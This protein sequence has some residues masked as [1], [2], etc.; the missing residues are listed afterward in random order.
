MYELENNSVVELTIE[1]DQFGNL[2]VKDK[3]E[4]TLY[5]PTVGVTYGICTSKKD[6]SVDNLMCVGFRYDHAPDNIY[7]LPVIIHKHKAVVASKAIFCE[8]V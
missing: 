8:V 5:T 6:G 4:A 7:S 1:I 2:I 3:I